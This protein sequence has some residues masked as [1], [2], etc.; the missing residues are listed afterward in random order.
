M[1]SKHERIFKDNIISYIT[2][3]IQVE[4]KDAVIAD[5]VMSRFPI[6]IALYKC[7]QD[8]QKDFISW[9]VYGIRQ[10]VRLNRNNIEEN[11]EQGE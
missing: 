4:S 10:T 8:M 3:R 5:E 1:I 6:W 2:N 7:S 9:L 11:I